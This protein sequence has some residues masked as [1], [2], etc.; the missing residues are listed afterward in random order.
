[1]TKTTWFTVS[2]LN[3]TVAH[4]KNTKEIWAN[5]E[6]PKSEQARQAVINFAVSEGFIMKEKTTVNDAFAYLSRI[7]RG[8]KN[9]Y[10]IREAMSQDH[11][12]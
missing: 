10:I 2:G 5:Y 3:V 11:S 6:R 9:S 1:M 7:F 4:N 8:A 12:V